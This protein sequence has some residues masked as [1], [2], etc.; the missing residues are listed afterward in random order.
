MTSIYRK[1][2][3]VRSTWLDVD[4]SDFYEQTKADPKGTTEET[5]TPHN[6]TKDEKTFKL[7][8]FDSHGGSY[9]EITSPAVLEALRSVVDYAPSYDLGARK[10]RIDWPY[11]LLIHHEDALAEYQERLASSDCIGGACPGT[12]AYRHISIVRNF[13]KA[14]VGAAV[15]VER[16]RHARGMATFEMLWLLFPPGIDVLYD[17]DNTGEYQPYVI[18]SQNCSV[19]NETVRSISFKL[20][21]MEYNVLSIC[22]SV[23]DDS[24]EPFAGEVKISSLAIYPFEY[25]TQSKIWGEKEDARQYFEERGKI[26]FQLRRLGCWNF[27]GYTTSYPRN[28]VSF[29]K[30]SFSIILTRSR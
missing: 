6:E 16:E 29:P 21:N 15:R 13:V 19:V 20:W 23:T 11:S 30:S 17:R 22:P 3:D 12:Y 25:R 18:R 24:I 4:A 7:P 1:V 14:A 2:V 5:E 26:Y 28:P 10:V 8:P 27:R 9:I